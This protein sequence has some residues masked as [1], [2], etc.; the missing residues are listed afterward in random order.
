MTGIG[1]REP[2]MSIILGVDERGK[3]CAASS[4]RILILKSFRDVLTSSFK[5]KKYTIRID[6]GA[7]VPAKSLEL[8]R[9]RGYEP[10][11]IGTGYV[12]FDGSPK[13]YLYPAFF[14][15]E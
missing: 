7:T 6:P 8:W 13:E 4:C 5:N 10:S 3:P 1:E 9:K 12:T 11:E 15:S 14:W 2:G